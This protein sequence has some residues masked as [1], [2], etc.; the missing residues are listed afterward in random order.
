MPDQLPPP[1]PP[2]NLNHARFQEMLNATGISNISAVP[3]VDV[4]RS[5]YRE[6]LGRHMSGTGGP[7]IAKI[8][9]QW[10]TFSDIHQVSPNIAYN[11]GPGDATYGLSW[12]DRTSTTTSIELSATVTAGIELIASASMTTTIGTSWT[13]EHASGENIQVTV[14]PG[15]LAWIDRG[16]L[17]NNIEGEFIWPGGTLVGFG[18]GGGP[19]QWNFFPFGG[20]DRPPFRWKGT[21]TGPGK[22]GALTGVLITSQQKADTGSLSS[23]QDIT[24]AAP[25]NGLPAGLSHYA[26][27]SGST[28]VTRNIIT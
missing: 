14:L 21:L 22:V 23:L 1:P 7:V 13:T 5:P 11:P 27:A 26:L 17:I 9:R 2:E 24:S 28:S 25:D 12:E 19:I 20:E 18:V 10:Y 3:E 6:R 15:Y 8:A 4:T 16:T